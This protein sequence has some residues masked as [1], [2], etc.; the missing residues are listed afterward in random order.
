MR[1][2]FDPDRNQLLGCQLWD[3]PGTE[4][5]KV[6]RFVGGIASFLHELGKSNLS[7]ICHHLE[8]LEKNK[9]FKTT[10][11]KQL[12]QNTQMYLGLVLRKEKRLKES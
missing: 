2:A 9:Y 12:Y 7:D 10:E 3:I 5:R 8:M 1:R 6:Y 11:Q 4:K